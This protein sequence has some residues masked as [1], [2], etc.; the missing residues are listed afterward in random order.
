MIFDEYN[1]RWEHRGQQEV[2]ANVAHHKAKIAKLVIQLCSLSLKLNETKKF[3]VQFEFAGH[4]DAI[5]L[6]YNFGSFAE[7][8]Q[9]LHH[10]YLNPFEHQC[11]TQELT[12]NA[13]QD[14]IN[15]LNDACKKLKK[16]HA[17]FKKSQQVVQ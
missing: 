4:V 16:A 9:L 12:D 7:N 6:F 8:C 3:N 2:T 5:H 1:R 10:L 14:I 15:K 11:R 13:Y 17:D